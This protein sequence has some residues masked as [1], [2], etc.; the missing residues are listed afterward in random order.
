MWLFQ[1]HFFTSHFCSTEF[2]CCQKHHTHSGHINGGPLP[3]KKKTP[4]NTFQFLMTAFFLGEQLEHQLLLVEFFL[5]AKVDLIGAPV[6]GNI[7]NIAVLAQKYAL[8][9]ETSLPEETSQFLLLLLLLNEISADALLFDSDLSPFP[10]SYYETPKLVYI[11]VSRL[12]M[13]QKRLLE[14]FL[15]GENF[16]L[17]KRLRLEDFSSLED[18]LLAVLDLPLFTCIELGS[19]STLQALE[20]QIIPDYRTLVALLA[21]PTAQI[22][23]TKQKAKLRASN[24]PFYDVCNNQNHCQQLAAFYMNSSKSY[25]FLGDFSSK[26][27]LSQTDMI[28]RLLEENQN[29]VTR[30][31]CECACKKAHYLPIVKAHT[32]MY[33][34]D[35][36]Y[37]DTCHKMKSCRYVHYFTL[38]PRLPDF[39]ERGEDK[40]V[41]EMYHE[42]TIGDCYTE[43][44]RE[45]PSA[46][47][48]NC[49]VR[50][51][52]F[53]ILGKFAAIVAD[54]A[55]DI[56]MS[57]P[58]GT[59]KD[60]EFLSLPVDLLQDEGIILLW[61]TG[62][63]IEIGRKALVQWGYQISDEL[64]WVKLNQLRR[65]I[66][67]GRTG[68]WLNHSK[69]HLL[70]G[71]KGNPQWL[72]IKMDMDVIVSGT[73]QTLRKPDEVYDVVERIVGRHARKLEIFGRDHNVRRGW[74]SKCVRFLYVCCY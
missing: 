31:A 54:P 41:K 2:T 67:T 64:I 8:D 9:R 20:D 4:T 7:T 33:L 19:S 53:Q 49:D 70:V 61:V 71:L 69:E 51:L 40:R 12:K 45:V 22:M 43:Y 56:H 1:P 46:Q 36:S 11:N 47:W 57:L 65:T 60:A 16:K 42:Y 55:W 18:C 27:S 29:S 10:R 28:F 23:L 5:S 14:E 13:L 68:H 15:G 37:L 34:G 72:N 52:P 35:C 48:I 30:E 59:C 21:K 74:I 66:V 32:D 17:P 44:S 25:I 62:R 26:L 24:R 50:Y 39:K 63:S 73:R 58:Y 3:N 38:Y 6:Y